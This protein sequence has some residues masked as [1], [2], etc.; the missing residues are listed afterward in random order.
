[1]MPLRIRG[2]GADISS[3]VC[4]T[5]GASITAQAIVE[6]FMQPP[7]LM[8]WGEQGKRWRVC[9]DEAQLP[10]GR[11]ACFVHFRVIANNRKVNRLAWIV[12]K[13]EDK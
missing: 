1:M 12:G 9:Q 6:A 3:P 4:P 8:F 5:C 10:D 7:T 2:D 13:Q 11:L